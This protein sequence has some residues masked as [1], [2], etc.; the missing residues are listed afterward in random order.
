M[1]LVEIVNYLIILLPFLLG[2]FLHPY[3]IT[4]TNYEKVYMTNKTK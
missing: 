2:P 1:E 4:F 3:F